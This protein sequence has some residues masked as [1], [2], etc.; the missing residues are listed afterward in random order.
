V[1]YQTPLNHHVTP[2]RHST[3]PTR[4][5]LPRHHELRGPYIFQSCKQ[6]RV[7]KIHLRAGSSRKCSRKTDIATGVTSFRPRSK[8]KNKDRSL[9]L[10]LTATL[11]DPIWPKRHTDPLVP[12]NLFHPERR[13]IPGQV[14]LSLKSH[15]DP[16]FRRQDQPTRPS[17]T[18]IF[19]RGFFQS[20]I[21]SYVD[22]FH[23]WILFIRGYSKYVE[24]HT[25]NQLRLRQP[26]YKPA[27][28]AS[29][30]YASL[31]PTGS[32]SFKNILR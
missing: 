28:T 10:D 17:A 19:S 18:W 26:S 14:H 29:R 22:S 25:W 20:W 23:T 3:R 32:R 2:T 1:C 8:V 6:T 24:V 31:P 30:Y 15:L 13:S 21:L 9:V 4:L 11:L 27:V 16:V 12:A 5:D 7:P